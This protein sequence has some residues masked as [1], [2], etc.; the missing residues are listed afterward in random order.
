MLV[1]FRVHDGS[2]V[3]RTGYRVG[4][5]SLVDVDFDTWVGTGVR[6]GEADCGR[7]S[8]AATR[9]LHLSTFHL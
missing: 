8:A 6:S 2:V 3:A 1:D 7:L 5:Q 9:D 4:R